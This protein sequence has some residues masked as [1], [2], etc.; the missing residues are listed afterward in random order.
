MNNPVQI[1]FDYN[2]EYRGV[3]GNYLVGVLCE[4][5]KI[6]WHPVGFRSKIEG[7]NYIAK[8]Y[9]NSIITGNI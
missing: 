2:P 5:G 6:S 1:R 4:N 9:P 3:G 7:E 8:H